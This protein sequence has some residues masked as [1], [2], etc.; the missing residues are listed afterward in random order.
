MYELE[1]VAIL[2]DCIHLGKQAL[3]VA[4]GIESSGNKHVLGL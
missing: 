2:I 3:V 1:L 4:L